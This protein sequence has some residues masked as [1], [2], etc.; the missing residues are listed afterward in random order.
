MSKLSQHDEK[1]NK[2]RNP[3]VH[4]VRVYNF[5]PKERDY[6]RRC[7]NYNDACVSRYVRVDC[8]QQLSPYNNV[9]RRP[10]NAGKDIEKCNC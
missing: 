9:D 1:D 3:G 2:A 5:V 8:I 10:A 7:C 4:L 6:E